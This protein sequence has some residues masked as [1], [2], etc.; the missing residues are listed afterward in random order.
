MRERRNPDRLDVI[1]NNGR[2]MIWAMWDEGISLTFD[3]SPDVISDFV[4]CLQAAALQT[5]A[6]YHEVFPTNKEGIEN[7]IDLRRAES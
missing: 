4:A 5:G 1:N 3:L 7:E 2:V 6:P